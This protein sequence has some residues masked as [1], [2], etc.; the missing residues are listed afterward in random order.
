MEELRRA[1][2]LEDGCQFPAQI[3]AVLHGHIHALPSF[4]AVRMAGVASYE[5]TRRAR[6]DLLLRYVIEPVAKSLADL[7][8]RPPCDLLHLKG[9][10]MQDSLRRSDHIIDGYVPARDPF[11]F[12]ELVELNIDA[13]QIAAF[14]GDDQDAAFVGRLYRRLQADVGE[15]GDRQYVHDAPGLIGRVPMKRPPEAA[16]HDA[17]RTVTTNH[18]TGLHGF[19][20]VRVL[21]I[22][23]L[24]PDGHRVGGR[25]DA[26][27]SCRVDLKIDHAPRIVRLQP[28]RCI[29][30]DLQVEIVHTRLVQDHMWKF[31]EPVFNILD[32]AAA[33]DVASLDIVG[34]PKRRLIDPVRLLQQAL[35]ESKSV[36]NL[37][38]ATAD[39]VCFAKE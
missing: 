36:E 14:T 31:G 22:D 24:E 38:G 17:A 4:R 26:G 11:V 25:A 32:P 5:H 8:D 33:D 2:S 6:P 15:I 19:H 30:H 27:G 35:A 3:E 12:L 9:V 13:D 1:P 18:I 20:L 7:V 28:V 34:L 39:P 29:A 23:P 21:G 10:G 37:H 16:A